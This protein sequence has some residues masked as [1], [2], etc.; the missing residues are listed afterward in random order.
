MTEKMEPGAESRRSVERATPPPDF[1]KGRLGAG[2]LVSLV[3][4]AETQPPMFAALKPLELA[5]QN[6]IYR[7]A[8]HLG[9]TRGILAAEAKRGASDPWR[10]RKVAILGATLV[11]CMITAF[12]GGREMGRAHADPPSVS[13]TQ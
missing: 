5:D 11:V 7:L 9:V 8:E 4:T 6:K 12:V 10:W 1:P 13:R 3:E 2:E